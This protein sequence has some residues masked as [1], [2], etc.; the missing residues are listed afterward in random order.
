MN[1][2]RLAAALA[3]LKAALTGTGTPDPARTRYER[4]IRQQYPELTPAEVTARVEA[5]AAK[6]QA[7]KRQPIAKATSPTPRE[8]YEDFHDAADAAA[9]AWAKDFA[10]AAE[11]TGAAI[12]L[13]A[14]EQALAAMNLAA[15]TALIDWDKMEDALRER[16]TKR[17]E[18][19]VKDGAEM[20]AAVLDPPL[21][22]DFVTGPPTGR[23]PVLTTAPPEPPASAT[24]NLRFDLTNPRSIDYIDGHTARLVREVSAES[25]DA[26]QAIV[27]QGFTGGIEMPD[28]TLRNL[29]VPEQARRIRQ[30][31]GL[32]ERQGR[33]VIRYAD[34]L[35]ADG[36]VR[37]D[38]IDGLVDA[39][40]ERLLRLRAET[41]SRTETIDALSQGQQ[42]LWE[43]AREQGFLDPERMVK[44]WIIT[45]DDK[46]C[47][48]ICAK[49]TGQ[50]A[51]AEI[52][53][54]FATPVG[55]KMGPTAHPNCRCAASLKRRPD[56]MKRAAT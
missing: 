37:A 48:K 31:I 12:D 1:R 35:L 6:R 21:K 54:P 22:V 23:V 50:R 34:R 30:V 40:A 10:A 44:F 8:P 2:A 14:L 39:Y 24:F 25:R 33:A 15:A 55:P 46:L 7:P 56:W 4:L 29:T 38:R 28:G 51:Y 43:E 18:D 20:T 5:F 45:P 13:V 26:I 53:E 36:S 41:I 11:T 52:D 9:V 27:R 42:L 49:M 47:A 3:K 19:L 17:V 16:W 32:T